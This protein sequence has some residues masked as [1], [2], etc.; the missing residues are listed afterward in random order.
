[1]CYSLY[2]F[3]CHGGPQPKTGRNAPVLLPILGLSLSSWGQHGVPMNIKLSTSGWLKRRTWPEARRTSIMWPTMPPQKTFESSLMQGTPEFTILSLSDIK[4]SGFSH[5]D[6][7][8]S[9]NRLKLSPKRWLHANTVSTKSGSP[10]LIHTVVSKDLFAS[11][12]KSWQHTL[13]TGESK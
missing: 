2:R 13:R 7:P 3:E 5:C 10:N 8:V 6:T 4:V 12:D 11:L 1:M 9:W